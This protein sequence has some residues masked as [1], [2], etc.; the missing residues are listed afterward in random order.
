[1]G[2]RH[3][4]AAWVPRDFHTSVKL[5]GESLDDDRTQSGSAPIQIQLALRG[6]NSV[7]ENRKSPVCLS[8]L[9]GD[10]KPASSPAGKGV[11]ERIDHELRDD[12]ADA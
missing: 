2:D 12:E 8:H 9:V 3:R 4:R 1:M 11:L 10:D 6:P 7:V 5:F